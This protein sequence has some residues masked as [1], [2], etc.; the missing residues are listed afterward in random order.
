[1]GSYD[2]AE[3]CELVGF[4]LLNLLT[5][6]FRKDN[7]GLYRDGGLSFFQN[8]SGLDSAKIKKKICKIFKENLLQ[9]VL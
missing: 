3:V 9:G 2:G 7:I 5:N 4:Y 8:I 6:E 1:M